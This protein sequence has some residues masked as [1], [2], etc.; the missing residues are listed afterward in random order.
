MA[1]G[2]VV[3]VVNGPH[4]FSW[5]LSGQRIVFRKEVTYYMGDSITGGTTVE[6]VSSGIMTRSNVQSTEKVRK[7]VSSHQS[8]HRLFGVT[9]ITVRPV[10]FP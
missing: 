2:Y 6:R 3:V 5:S 8:S 10:A 4:K 7:V 1:S 9:G